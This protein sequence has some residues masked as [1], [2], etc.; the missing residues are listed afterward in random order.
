[1]CGKEL[2]VLLPAMATLPKRWVDIPPLM[3]RAQLLADIHNSLGHCGWDKLL[4]AL[5]GSYWWPGI[6]ADIADGV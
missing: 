4:S 1:M 6:H 2:Q 5:L 3:A